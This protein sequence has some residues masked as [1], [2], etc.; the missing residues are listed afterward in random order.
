VWDER[1][2][3][4]FG[5]PPDA[6]TDYSVF[7]AGVHPDDRERMHQAVQRAIDPAGSGDIDEEFRTIGFGDGGRLRW[8]AT[9][10]RAFRRPDGTVE[11][12]VGTVVDVT[13]AKE[14]ASEREAFALR[15]RRFLR[16]MLFAMTEGR[17][18]LC[19]SEADL[20]APLPAICPP[21]DLT[22]ETLRRL[23]RD[24]GTAS[25]LLDHSVERAHDLVTAVGEAAKNAVRHAGGGEG[26]VHGAEATG[27]VQVWVRDRGRGISDESLH[28]ATLE[29]GFSTAAGFGHG[30]W[31]MLRTGDRLYLHTSSR[32]TTV[33]LEQDRTPPSP[34]WL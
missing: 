10:G 3:A 17:L 16:E 5:L 6:P 1:C 19:E 31:L 26:R 2:K 7:L 27:T 24:A 32:G 23:R 14:R 22:L 33:V 13:E 20:P 18:R 8:I 30:F 12:F 9:R 28:R 34:S 29:R 4:F 11:R 21:V 15:Q 25:E